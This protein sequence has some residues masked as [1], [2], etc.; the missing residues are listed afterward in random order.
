M[1]AASTSAEAA[2]VESGVESSGALS[3]P[4]ASGDSLGRTAASVM[5]PTGAV[6]F[7]LGSPGSGKDTQCSKLE[8]R[9]GCANLSPGDLLRSE[10]QSSS[11]QGKAISDMIKS[12]QIVPAQMTL[13]L[14]KAAMSARAGPYV[15][16]GFPKS[17]DNL[18]E[19]EA[20]CGRCAGAIVYEAS[21]HVLTERMLERG[22]TS[23]RTDDNVEVIGRRFRTH[24]QQAVP[25][26]DVLAASGALGTHPLSMRYPSATHLLPMRL[27]IRYPSDTH[28]PYPSTLPTVLPHS[29]M[30]QGSSLAS[31]PPDPSTRSLMLLR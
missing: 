11:A 5:K 19:Y 30:S 3:A 2:H 31:M 28:L 18:E 9:F 26:I 27:P 25:V 20:Q 13:D 10:V 7:V 22:K 24:Q 29:R 16:N 12:G 1:P 8:D 6:I 17:L 15:I 21:E 23:G 14:L 4:S